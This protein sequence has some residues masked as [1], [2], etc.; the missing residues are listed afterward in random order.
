MVELPPPSPIPADLASQLGTAV[1]AYLERCNYQALVE[2]LVNEPCTQ[3][4]E[5]QFQDQTI[6]RLQSFVDADAIRYVPDNTRGC[7]DALASLECSPDVEQLTQVCMNGFVGTQMTGDECSINEVCWGESFCNPGDACPGRCEAKRS[8]TEVCED[9]SWCQTGLLCIRGLCQPASKLDEEC[10][11]GKPACE[12]GLYCT[13]ENGAAGTCKTFDTDLASEREACN[14]QAGPLCEAGLSCVPNISGFSLRFRCEA[15]VE[16][17]E[18]CH[19]G[20]PEHCQDGFYCDGTDLTRPLAPDIDGRCRPLPE[21]GEDCGD[22]PVGKVCARNL[23]CNGG[24][25]APR[26][27][28]GGACE[29]DRACYSGACVSQ[30]CGHTQLCPD[31]DE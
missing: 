11:G 25:C 26:V 24:T 30:R 17:G 14:I 27:R 10:G 18:E 31:N 21:A 19:P 5:R 6:D 4:I 23:V 16:E 15:R 9:A 8:A 20:L 12:S 28:V 2:T 29:E 7:L 13:G 3:F 22:A 1:C